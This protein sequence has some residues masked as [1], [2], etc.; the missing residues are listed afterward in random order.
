[1]AAKKADCWDF[2]ECGREPGGKNTAELGI[3]P[4]A[5]EELYDG[6][7]GGKNG[8]RFCWAVTSTLCGGIQQGTFARKLENC[9]KCDFF[10]KVQK[11]EGR[12][13]ILIP[14]NN[15]VTEGEN[16]HFLENPDSLK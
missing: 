11:D 16:D 2:T 12:N 5:T 8:G 15:L 9:L 14:P 10:L 1:M 13:F 7:N 3:C 4:A 6:I